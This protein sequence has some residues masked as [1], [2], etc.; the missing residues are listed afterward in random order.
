MRPVVGPHGTELSYVVRAAGPAAIL[1]M[2]GEIDVSS[3]PVFRRGLEEAIGSG[4]S[5]VIID[6]AGVSFLDSMGL[7]VL[8]GVFRQLAPGNV[9]A[10]ARV[11]LRMQRVLRVAALDALMEVHGEQEPWPWPDIPEPSA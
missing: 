6:M 1:Q 4:F 7:S 5:R 2:S 8:L 3:S 10:V 11:P 9:L